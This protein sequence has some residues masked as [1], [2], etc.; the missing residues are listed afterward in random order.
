MK[1]CKTLTEVLVP[2][3]HVL[4]YLGVVSPY[5]LV[6][7]DFV[8]LDFVTRVTFFDIEKY[9]DIITFL[10]MRPSVRG[11]VFFMCSDL[12]QAQMDFFLEMFHC[13]DTIEFKGCPNVLR[14]PDPDRFQPLSDLEGT[15]IRILNNERTQVLSFPGSWHIIKRPDPLLSHVDVVELVLSSISTGSSDALYNV[16]QFYIRGAFLSIRSLDRL[17]KH[18]RWT[19]VS[20]GVTD[21]TATVITRSIMGREHANTI[22]EW[23]LQKRAVN[24]E[25]CWMLVELV[26]K[27]VCC[28]RSSVSDSHI[29][30]RA[31]RAPLNWSISYILD[32]SD[33]L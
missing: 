33:T 19:V 31:H 26:E 6:C 18:D 32:M 11:V 17:A 1:H 14:L 23:T 12:Y 25:K 24:G 8:P 7:R 28:Y 10:S 15:S 5:R 29:E 13:L 20:Q 2:S 30:H 21:D 9:G 16:N 27:C 4:K 3:R 22:S